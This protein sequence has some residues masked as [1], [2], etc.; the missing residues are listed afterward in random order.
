MEEMR[1]ACDIMKGES[2]GTFG[3]LGFDV[4]FKKCM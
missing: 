3:D 2:N 1:N 4:I